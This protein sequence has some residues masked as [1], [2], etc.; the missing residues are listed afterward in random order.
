MAQRSPLTLPSPRTV[1]LFALLVVG[2]VGSFAFHA[3]MTDMQV[4]YT[5][6]AVHSGDDPGRI[7]HASQSVTDLDGRLEGKSGDV[8]RPV[9]RA[10]RNGS[11]TGNVTPELYTILNGMDAK[12]AVYDGSY[13]RWNAT[14]SDETTFVEMRMTPT[15][16][17]SV[18]ETVS[19]P[20]G[21]ASAKVQEAI[22]TGSV[23]GR[24]MVEPG[25]YRRGDTYYAVAPENPA[26]SQRTSSR[27]SSAPCSRRSA[28]GSS[29]SH[30]GFWPPNPETRSPT[31]C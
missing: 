20:Y 11:F 3:A 2:L 6:T 14:V 18:L 22:G 29:R 23:T 21:T 10:A 4:T 12:L 26:R 28:A 1:A 24:E 13:Y 19:K 9:Q 27:R 17:P 25:V 7:V 8:R 31:A 16:Q 30:S 5:A 15:D